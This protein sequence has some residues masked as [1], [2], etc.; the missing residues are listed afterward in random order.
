MNATE[1]LSYQVDA[2]EEGEGSRLDIHVSDGTRRSYV[3]EGRE[4]EH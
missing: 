1:S 2:A 3:L 4:S